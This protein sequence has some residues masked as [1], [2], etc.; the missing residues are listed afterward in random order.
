MKKL[1]VL[2]VMS[3]IT[4]MSLV[5]CK[6]PAPKPSD[7]DVTSESSAPDVITPV[8][9]AKVK[10]NIENLKNATM[11]Q[12]MGMEET[13]KESLGE[14]LPD[15]DTFELGESIG[16]VK[17]DEKGNYSIKSTGNSL[18]GYAN[19]SGLAKELGIS[20]DALVQRLGSE[21]KYVDL[22]NDRAIV[23]EYKGGSEQYEWYYEAE[24]QRIKY[25]VEDDECRY[26]LDQNSEGDSLN[27]MKEILTL[28]VNSGVL[29][30]KTST[31]NVASSAIPELAESGVENLALFVENNYPKRL[32]AKQEGIKI[33]FTLSDFNSTTVE[34]PSDKVPEKCDHQSSRSYE[35]LGNQHRLY[36][37]SCNKYLEPKEDHTLLSNANH[38]YCT[39]CNKI[40]N[41]ESAEKEKRSVEIND[42]PEYF[43]SAQKAKDNGKYYVSSR[44]FS[45]KSGR[46][47]LM[48]TTDFYA[49]YWPNEQLLLTR[50]QYE[51]RDNLFA[52]LN[53]PETLQYSCYSATKYTFEVF[54]DIKVSEY[55]AIG[56]GTFSKDTYYAIKNSKNVS[57]SLEAYYINVSHT[58]GPEVREDLGNCV[59]YA[60]SKCTVCNVKTNSY[61][62]TDH[63]Y[64]MSKATKVSV[65]DCH[66]Q[67]LYEC[68]K[69]HNKG[70]ANNYK[71]IADHK[72]ATYRYLTSEQSAYLKLKYDVNAVN[73]Y[74]YVEVSCPT[75]KEEELYEFSG[76]LY[77]D[78]LKDLP[79]RANYVYTIKGDDVT[80]TY[81]KYIN[82]PHTPDKYGIC[83]YCGEGSIVVTVTEGVKILVSYSFSSGTDVLN[84]IIVSDQ[85]F[86]YDHSNIETIEGNKRKTTYYADQEGTQVICSYITTNM[87]G[88]YLEI[89]D[90]AGKS[91]YKAEKGQ[92]LPEIN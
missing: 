64:D 63:E 10:T 32:S 73:S 84:Y 34:I 62:Y 89:F 11:K 69:C 37:N 67:L 57:A 19:L 90:N 8:D 42:K 44:E 85:G 68:K 12:Y 2:L 46:D 36:C 13:G 53:A 25:D 51:P 49:V 29:D 18:R 23:S 60:E 88:E 43:I 71:K 3:M 17:I 58:N 77:S 82:I 28:V 22:E 54:K 41:T 61:Y 6:K 72:N 4:M 55:P 80:R 33:E 74:R 70:D 5:G 38:N 24:K 14:G 92:P 81:D 45:Y 20:R 78:H 35:E 39:L 27:E 31:I 16:I 15:I 79:S 26:V 1:N 75:C 66:Y 83:K 91:V 47:T 7:S 52:N 30:R 86:A 59:T 50:K 9:L 76:S 65:D 48:N 87:Y 21:V 40:I 56:D